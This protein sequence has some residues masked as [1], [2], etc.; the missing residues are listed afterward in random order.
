MKA[1]DKNCAAIYRM[2]GWRADTVIHLFSDYVLV[3]VDVVMATVFGSQNGA[4]VAL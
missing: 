2:E 3:F 1:F 4:E